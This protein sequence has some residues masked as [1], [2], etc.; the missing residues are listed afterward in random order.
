M[1]NGHKPGPDDDWF[2]KKDYCEKILEQIKSQDAPWQKP[3][4]PGDSLAPFNPVSGTIYK[5]LNRLTLTAGQFSDPRWLTFIQAGSKGWR[6]KSG[7]S[8]HIIVHWQWTEKSVLRDNYGRPLM[9]EDGQP[10][11]TILDLVRPRIRRFTVFNASQLL[12]GDGRSL[13]PYQPL[14]ISWQPQETAE[15]IIRECG[16]HVEHKAGDRC[17]YDQQTDIVCLTPPASFDEAGGYYS[18]VF[19]ELA[20][21]T[22][23]PSRFDRDSGRHGD[24]LYAREELVAELVAWMMCQDL[25]LPFDPGN[26]MKYM[27]YWYRL[28]SE[29]RCDFQRVCADADKIRAF[30]IDFVP[31]LRQAELDRV[32]ATKN[33]H[34]EGVTGGQI[35]EIP[36]TTKPRKSP[37]RRRKTRVLEWVPSAQELT[38]ANSDDLGSDGPEA[39]PSSDD[40]TNFYGLPITEAALG[41]SNLAAGKLSSTRSLPQTGPSEKSEPSEKP[42][43]SDKSWLSEKSSA[44][45]KSTPSEKSIPPAPGGSVRAQYQNS[46]SNSPLAK[47]GQPPLKR[48]HIDSPV[49][50]MPLIPEKVL[51]QRDEEKLRASV[52][53][54]F[55]TFLARPGLATSGGERWRQLVDLTKQLT[56]QQWCWDINFISFLEEAARVANYENERIRHWNRTGRDEIS[57]E[58]T[59]YNGFLLILDAARKLGLNGLAFQNTQSRPNFAIEN[60]CYDPRPNVLAPVK[61]GGQN[62]VNFRVAQPG[63]PVRG[64]AVYRIR[65]S[66]VVMIMRDHGHTQDI[67]QVLNSSSTSLLNDEGDLD[68]QRLVKGRIEPPKARPKI[69]PVFTDE[70]SV[71]LSKRLLERSYQRHLGQEVTE[72]FFCPGS[73]GYHRLAQA[74][75]APAVELEKPAEK[76]QTPEPSGP[77]PGL[78]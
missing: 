47:N 67:C 43:S 72:P 78:K 29:D 60:L 34:S 54:Q 76:P 37:A 71:A 74:G 7:A 52:V 10:L 77:A 40:E 51:T 65:D 31:E 14:P 27:H 53:N 18:T 75:N 61:I 64:Y 22:K 6:V 70:E 63:D 56:G 41:R 39:K 50:R 4:R 45:E 55:L 13:E 11:S 23:H 21:W 15:K 66:E 24:A 48:S 73:P 8:G 5:G 49:L 17:Y 36:K 42:G 32:A 35:P 57:R 20:H 19:H 9:G 68:S 2:K 30:F 69:H 44:S 28:V 26:S 62:I 46:P 59:I 38:E 1:G 33:S 3:W 58:V 25:N 16:A 12:T